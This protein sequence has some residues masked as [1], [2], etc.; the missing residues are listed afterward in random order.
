ME[1][2]EMQAV[3]SDSIPRNNRWSYL[4]QYGNIHYYKDG[5]IRNLVQYGIGSLL[6]PYFNDL[7]HIVIKINI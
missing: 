5:Y 3:W 7:T 2:E 1:L 4:L 6:C